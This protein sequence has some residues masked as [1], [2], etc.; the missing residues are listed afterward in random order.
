[1]RNNW[2]DYEDDDFG[3]RVCMMDDREALLRLYSSGF[4]VCCISF[5]N[6]DE[7]EIAIEMCRNYV[8][9]RGF[10]ENEV[11]IVLR[12]NIVMVKIK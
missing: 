11:K 4:V 1:M 3:E 5:D 6:D 10:T 8:K 2:W 9:D 12:E 7:K